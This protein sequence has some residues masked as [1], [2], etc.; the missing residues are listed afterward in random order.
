M[1]VSKPF[2]ILLADTK[3]AELLFLRDAIH[4]A[5]HNAIVMDVGVLRQPPFTP[6]I[7]HDAVAAA[8][9]MERDAIIALGDE[10]LAMQQM[11]KGAASLAASLLEDDRI[12]GAL[13][14]GGTMATDLALDVM[15]ALP[16]GVPKVI[17]STIAFSHLIPGGRPLGPQHGI[18]FG[19]AS[20]RR[21]GPRCRRG[22]CRQ[23]AVGTAGGRRQFARRLGLPLPRSSEAVAR[24]A[25]LR[26]HRLPRDRPRRPGAR[27]AG[28]ARTLG[29]SAR[30]LP[31][32]GQQP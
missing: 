29:R 30:S 3:A 6:E 19:T 22:Q 20:G 10:N 31:R 28:R 8:S 25:R 9:G 32:R 18:L 14:I 24:R 21:R 27:S 11:A 12:D 23:D 2:T 17:V 1:S 4:A 7:D 5:G 15:A 26:S 16:L 13:A